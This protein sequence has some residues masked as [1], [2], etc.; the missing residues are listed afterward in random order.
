M[1]PAARDRSRASASQASAQRQRALHR[2]DPGERHAAQDER[3][4]RVG[5]SGPCAIP[6]A[7]TVRPRRS[8]E[9]VG[10]RCCP[11]RRSRRSAGTAAGGPLDSSRRSSTSAAP[12]SRRY[13]FPD[14]SG[15]GEDLVPAPARAR[16]RSSLPRRRLR[17]QHVSGLR[18]EA[19]ILEAQHREHRGETCGADRGG[20]FGGE[21]CGQAHQGVGPHPGPGRE[22]AV[23]GLADPVAVEDH[24]ITGGEALVGR[25][26]R[27]G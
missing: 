9:D 11:R 14:P 7:A 16:P 27:A 12:S 24:Q 23:A 17:D 6:Q 22:A 13:S 20:P 2:V 18:G 4:N 21:V 8:S 1:S 26:S 3:R 10:E 5:R 19:R 25:T 15:R